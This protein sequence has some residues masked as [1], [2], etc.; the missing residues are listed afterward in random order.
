M[1]VLGTVV[2]CALFLLTV[3]WFVWQTVRESRKATKAAQEAVTGLKGLLTALEAAAQA[4]RETVVA[5]EEVTFATGAISGRA[6]GQKAQNV[7]A[8][9]K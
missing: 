9:R 5:D 7:P 2:N 3:V 6:L 8:C 1:D 4:A